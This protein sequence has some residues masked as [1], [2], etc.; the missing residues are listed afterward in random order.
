MEEAEALADRVG[1]IDHGR[2]IAEGAPGALVRQMGAD[3]V[4]MVGTGAADAFV[5]A[6]SAMS[7]VANAIVHRQ[8]DAKSFGEN[9]RIPAEFVVQIGV[10]AGERRL[11]EMVQLAAEEGFHIHEVSVAKPSLGDVFLAFTGHELR[12]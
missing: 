7:F 2:L 8:D 1:I 5:T 11:V 9:Q 10:D 3:V 12:D 4:S 6:A